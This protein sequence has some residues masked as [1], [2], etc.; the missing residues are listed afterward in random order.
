MKIKYIYLIETLSNALDSYKPNSYYVIILLQDYNL[1]IISAPMQATNSPGPK[2]VF[3]K[4]I[5]TFP[6]SQL[7][8]FKNV[9]NFINII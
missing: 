4:R 3:I 5:L 1:F 9:F 7:I 2:T 8:L 6:I